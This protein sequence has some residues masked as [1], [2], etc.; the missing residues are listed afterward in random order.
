[1][2]FLKTASWQLLLLYTI[3]LGLDIKIVILYRIVIFVNVFW[4]MEHRKQE[5]FFLLRFP[6][7]T[8][9]TNHSVL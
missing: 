6:F 7:N 1:M 4:T 2:K 3:K 9:S 5:I 8:T